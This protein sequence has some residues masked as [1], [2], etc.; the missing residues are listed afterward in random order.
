[1]QPTEIASL[2]FQTDGSSM[3][4]GCL[5]LVSSEYEENSAYYQSKEKSAEAACAARA[6]SP[7]NLLAGFTCSRSLLPFRDISPSLIKRQG[8][9]LRR[10]RRTRRHLGYRLGL[11]S[12]QSP[13]NLCEQPCGVGT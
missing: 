13:T 3:I 10:P 8:F 4:N 7:S 5:A 9:T 6:Q 1:M 2:N 11:A 12:L